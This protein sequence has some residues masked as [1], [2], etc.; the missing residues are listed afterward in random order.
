MGDVSLEETRKL[1]NDAQSRI[2]ILT[3]ALEYF[4]RVSEDLAKAA[5]RGVSISVLMRT[6]DSLDESD[7]E[8]RDA[9]ITQIREKLGDSVEIR[10]SPEVPLRG[11]IVDPDTEGRALFLVEERG[12][13]YVFREAAI[14]SHPGVVRGL[15]SMFELKWKFDS[16]PPEFR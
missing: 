5:N 7:A 9:A 10:A 14:T 8:K 2:I 6:R 15:T 1:Y 3:R 12:I 16:R 11:C 4:P 13:P